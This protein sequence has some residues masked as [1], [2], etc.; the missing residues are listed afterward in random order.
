V[1]GTSSGFPDTL[2]L[3]SCNGS[4]C[5][6]FDGAINTYTGFSVAGGDVNGDGVA[7]IIVAAP[8]STALGEH[9]RASVGLGHTGTLN[10]TPQALYGG[11][12]LAAVTWSG[13]GLSPGA[14]A[15]R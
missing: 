5:A 12:P 6:E 9:G 8:S 14:S 1:F 3:T 2:P 7:D 4:N 11:F 15:P 10:A 13:P